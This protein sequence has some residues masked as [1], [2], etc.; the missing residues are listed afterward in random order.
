MQSYLSEK[1][2]QAIYASM[3][4]DEAT[5]WSQLVRILSPHNED[6]EFTDPDVIRWITDIR[7]ILKGRQAGPLSEAER[8][9]LK[10]AI[11]EL[12]NHLGRDDVNLFTKE[13]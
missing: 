4:T 5:C 13:K 6:R 9:T 10:T 1:L 8:L 12:Y 2:G 3:F 7:G 11:W